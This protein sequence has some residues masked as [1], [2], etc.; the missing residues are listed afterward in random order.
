MSITN[1]KKPCILTAIFV[2]LSAFVFHNDKFLVIP[3]N[4]SYIVL[5]DANLIPSNATNYFFNS[6]GALCLNRE[7]FVF[8]L[9]ADATDMQ[10]T[11]F[12]YNVSNS[13]ICCF[14]D[15]NIMFISGNTLYYAQN[16]EYNAFLDIPLN[17]PRLEK[18]GEAGAY[19]WGRKDNGMYELLFVSR[20]E[21]VI[22]KLLSNR[23]AIGA[24][25]G[26][27]ETAFV[28]VENAIYLLDDGTMYSLH[29]AQGNIIS[30]AQAKNGIFYATDS[31]IAYMDTDRAT[32]FGKGEQMHKLMSFANFLYLVFRNGKIALIT[33]T[34][35]FKDL[36]VE[37]Q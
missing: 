19:L 10:P 5:A 7:Q 37:Y 13:S 24:V 29:K 22:K 1:L 8:A 30:L 28:A 26:D 18:A 2:V 14:A 27:G 12:P 17:G 11:R 34:E 21:Q 23:Q 25:M 20:K 35:N 15:G 31:E 32:V 16:G 3:A 33:D 4:S 9:D 36:L 6:R